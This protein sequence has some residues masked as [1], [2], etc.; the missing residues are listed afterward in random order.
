MQTL[1]E[2]PAT[3]PSSH[4]SLTVKVPGT[5]TDSGIDLRFV[6]RGGDIHLSV[7]T[8]NADVAQQ[9]RGGLNDLVGRLEQA[10][11]HA[12]V[13]SQSANHSNTQ[14]DSQ[15]TSSS[16]DG[17]SDRRGFAQDQGGAQGQAGA[18]SQ[19]GSRDSNQSRWLQTLE[20]SESDPIPSHD[21]SQEQ[22]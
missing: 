19:Q 15:D 14:P 13:S 21:F 6:D 4:H 18:E 11:I 5:T 12:E 20:D 16:Q 2:A 17:S 1:I 8:P 10:G 9:L 3:P 7:R 22:I